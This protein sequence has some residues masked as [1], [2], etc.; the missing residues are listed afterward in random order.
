MLEPS[1]RHTLDP[2]SAPAA[3]GS[4]GLRPQASGVGDPA[5]L[6]VDNQDN[7]NIS[8]QS[9]DS[10]DSSPLT[11]VKAPS[12]SIK[13]V[14]QRLQNARITKPEILVSVAASNAQTA[15]YNAHCPDKQEISRIYTS[16]HQCSQ[17][18]QKY[19]EASLQL[20][21]D[22]PKDAD[23]WRIYPH[24]PE[25]YWI[26]GD[27]QHEGR[28][29]HPEEE[30]FRFEDCVFPKAHTYTF[31]M[32]EFGV[33][34]VY[35][36]ERKVVKGEGNNTNSEDDQP[37]TRQPVYKIPTLKEYFKDLD[38]VLDVV[39]DGPTKTF[40]F[41]RLKYLEAKWTMYRL[42]NEQNELND[43]KK[44]PHRDFYNV[45]K[46]DTHVHHSSSMNQKH[47]LRFI[48]KKIKTSP[49]DVVI[50]RDDKYLTL[51]EVFKSLNLT[52]YDLNINT[53]DMHAHQDSFHRFDK[54]NLKYNPIGESRLRE[55]FLKTD[56]YIEG[57]YLAELTKEVFSD[58]E[59]SKYQMAEYRISIYGRSPGEW[60]R[61]AKW[62]IN[63]KLFSH[64][65]R[66][67]VQVPRLYNIYKV[68]GT[69][70]SFEDI[71]RNVFQPLFEV[72]RD[73]SSHPELHVF[74]QRMVGFDSVD[75][76]SKA[77]RRIFKKYPVPR[78]W[79][80]L[81][82][83]PYSYY[84]Y[85]MYANIASLNRWRKERGFNTF[86]FRPHCGE[87]G[88]TDHLASAFITAQGISHGILLRKVPAMQYL[89]YLEQIGMAMSP[90]SNN[91][92]F[93]DF[94]KNPFITFFQRGLNVSLSTDDPLQFHF[95]KEPLIEE[96]SI[97]AQI[98]KLSSTDMCEISRNSVLQ[99]G[100]ELQVKR[101]WLG[102]KCDMEGPEGNDMRKT[103]VP[104]RRIEFRHHTLMEERGMMIQ[105]AGLTPLDNG[106]RVETKLNFH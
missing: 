87:A 14:S 90:L 92:L 20:P 17:I 48:K 58:L 52:A 106:Q 63:N 80:S 82:N 28:H 55:I 97:A 1:G 65:V 8:E 51:S 19:M 99:S 72:T 84:S 33:Y 2:L 69:V 95:T 6:G 62:V 85:Y 67:L 60:D 50:Y 46:V 86:T 22:N 103:N 9:S 53:L 59:A 49:E 40:A 100:W 10:G 104:N 31:D 32:D 77:E 101:H 56:N 29:V 5:M 93:L 68:N 4:P 12:V 74:L 13:E 57:R 75:D 98:W 38:F 23:D 54:F 41:R 70:E 66:W 79:N 45:R 7:L 16:I 35:S 94:D 42:L 36:S 61:L 21:N 30:E 76:E 18:R 73:P 83:P 26:P 78:L 96:Y 47:L 3:P 24:A 11:G 27:G 89:Y 102:D 43:S 88:D 44:V 64:N 91:A 105:S 37:E 39:A 34:Q 15:S 25:P 71:V 81:L